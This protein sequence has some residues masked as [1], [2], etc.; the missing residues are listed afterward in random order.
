MNHARPGAGVGL[1]EAP[2]KLR[3]TGHALDMTEHTTIKVPAALRDQ[4]RE[5]AGDRPLA[6]ALAD[7]VAE[8][9]TRLHRERFAFEAMLAKAQSD[10]EVVSTAQRR[11]QAAVH[12]LHQKATAE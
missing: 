12:L 10:P 3:Y 2:S 4:L 7:L 1:S 9:R 6:D 11:A 5:I 8:H